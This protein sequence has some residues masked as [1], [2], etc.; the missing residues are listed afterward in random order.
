MAAWNNLGLRGS[1]HERSSG[2]GRFGVDGQKVGRGPEGGTAQNLANDGDAAA[3]RL[4]PC[5]C[6]YSGDGIGGS[7]FT[8]PASGQTQKSA[9]RSAARL[10]AAARA[11]FRELQVQDSQL[12]LPMWASK[13][14]YVDNSDCVHLRL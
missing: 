9:E 3:S 1:L 2:S 8:L 11:I 14:A 6:G 5:W 7:G 10:Q 4:Q 13:R 12:V